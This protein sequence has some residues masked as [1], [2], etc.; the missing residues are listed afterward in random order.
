LPV[1]D[2]VSAPIDTP[3]RTQTPQIFAA[4]DGGCASSCSEGASRGPAAVR[5]GRT[6]EGWRCYSLAPASGDKT[7]VHLDSSRC[8]VDSHHRHIA[9]RGYP[10]CSG[11]GDAD[12]SR[13]NRLEEPSPKSN[14]P[15]TSPVAAQAPRFAGSMPIRSCAAHAFL[16][17]GS[18]TCRFTCLARTAVHPPRK[19]RMDTD[20]ERLPSSHDP[21]SFRS[22]VSPL[23]PSGLTLREACAPF[24][25][26]S[27]A[28]RVSGTTASF[29]LGH[30]S[31]GS[32]CDSPSI[33][34]H[35]ASERL[36]PPNTSTTSTRASWV[37]D[38]FRR[39]RALRGTENRAFHD[40]RTASAGRR[41][42]AP[43]RF[44]PRATAESRASDTPVASSDFRSCRLRAR[45]R[46]S[47]AAET[48]FAAPP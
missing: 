4:R 25:L 6:T 10:F 7:S 47:E 44:L 35:D 8:R 24:R 5:A 22:E 32:S 36:L 39:T 41:A 45:T 14:R 29:R 46:V 19:G 27:T 31:Y 15:L 38:L 1:V 23:A 13:L 30:D 26:V 48:V 20:P 33:V 28:A 12:P 3:C 16:L 17:T 9:M 18:R 40:A 11:T 42:S 21:S 43:G 2:A 37:S 34:T